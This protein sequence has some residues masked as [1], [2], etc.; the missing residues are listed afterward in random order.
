MVAIPTR[1]PTIGTATPTTWPRLSWVPLENGVKRGDGNDRP[2]TDLD[3]PQPFGTDQPVNCAT[4][5]IEHEPR[6]NNRDGA[7][8]RAGEGGGWTCKGSERTD[9]SVCVRSPRSS[10][11][12]SLRFRVLRP[13]SSIPAVIQLHPRA[14]IRAPFIVA[15]VGQST[16]TLQPLTSCQS[17]PIRA[18]IGGDDAKIVRQR[19]A[20]D[21]TM[22]PEYG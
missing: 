20:F 9:S 14:P 3:R 16:V 10:R 19:A 6:L 13:S 2:C 21:A 18:A 22:E 8:R 12:A 1:I 17:P 7:G 11:R 15:Q 5:H 4:G